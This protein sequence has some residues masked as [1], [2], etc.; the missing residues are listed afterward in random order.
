MDRRNPWRGLRGLPPELWVLFAV[1]LV[2][3]IGTMVLPF[4]AL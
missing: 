4:L 2:N 3:R 1:T